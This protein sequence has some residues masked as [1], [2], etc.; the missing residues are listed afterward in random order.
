MNGLQLTPQD[1]DQIHSFSRTLFTFGGVDDVRRE[2]LIFFEK[3]LGA[4][5]GNFFLAES[6]DK[7]VSFYRI[8][9][10]GIEDRALHHYRRYYWRIDPFYR[11]YAEQESSNLSDVLTTEDVVSFRNLVRTEYYND[12]LKPQSIHHQMT[13]HLKS[14]KNILGVVALFR[15]RGARR[16]STQD[17]LK[18]FVTAPY[19]CGAL[20]AAIASEKNRALE[21]VILSVIPDLPYK[22][23]VILDRFLEPIYQDEKAVSIL[24]TLGGTKG[25]NAPVQAIPRVIYRYCR[26]SAVCFHESRDA[27]IQEHQ[28]DLLSR[29]SRQKISVKVRLIRDKNNEP[30]FLLFFD[31]EEQILCMSRYLHSKGLTRREVEV[32]HLLSKGYRNAEIAER[33]FISEYTVENHLR[34]VYRK[35]D[36]PN[37]TAVVHHLLQRSP[38]ES[39]WLA[40]S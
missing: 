8:V 19:L 27:G 26:E 24:S 40:S 13:I 25:K 14:G 35:L 29:G 1:Q 38:Q 15:G 39:T 18:A 30:L 20:K 23:L 6:P 28:F 4:E 16:F 32:V 21:S 36:V 12:F 34:S 10:R 11:K 5:K 3:A 33:L 37:R 2:T 9:N 22:G 31:P 17:K 7:P